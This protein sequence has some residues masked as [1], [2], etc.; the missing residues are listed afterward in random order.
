MNG[1]PVQPETQQ[2]RLA[3]FARAAL[4]HYAFSPQATVTLL[5][6]SEN[7]TYRVDDPADG[8][9]A[10]L[11]VHRL[12][13]HSRTAIASELAWSAALREEAGIRTPVVIPSREGSDIVTV[14][15]PGSTEERHCVLFVFESGREPD[16]DR[17][18]ESFQQLGEVTARMHVHSRSWRRPTWFERFTWDYHTMLGDAPHWGRWQ[19]GIG[20]GPDELAVLDPLAQTLQRRLTRFGQSTDRFGLVHADMRLANLLLDGDQTKVIDFDDCGFSWYLYDLASAVSFIE[21]LP[22]VPAIVDS[23]LR[24]YRRVLPVPAEDEAE[25]P[26]FIMLRRLLLVAWIGS[27]ADTELARSQGSEFTKVTCDLAEQYLSRF[28]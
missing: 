11:R 28:A 15:L 4:S 20:M 24:G 21:H 5:N 19:A 1:S 2:D 25:I 14:R 18:E 12:G 10:V 8:S 27:H 17:L 7:G 23:W 16:E 22:Q 3:R 26:T 9:R 13:Y 6:L